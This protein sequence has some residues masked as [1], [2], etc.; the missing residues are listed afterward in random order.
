MAYLRC[1]ACGS[2]ALRAA[3]QCP[4][5]AAPFDLID[6]RGFRAQLKQCGGCGILHRRDLSCHWCG[7]LPAA[8]WRS[9]KV[10]GIAAG[11]AL[12]AMAASGAYRFRAPIAE[13]A[14]LIVA[15]VFEDRAA[16]AAAS[17]RDREALSMQ[18]A[19]SGAPSSVNTG[20]PQTVTTDSSG[21]LLDE[22][23]LDDAELD[24][25]ML[26]A[27]AAGAVTSSDS[28]VWTPAVARTWV[29]VRNDASRGGNVVGVINPSSRALLGTTRSGWRQVKSTD[30]TGWVDPKLFEADSTRTRG[31]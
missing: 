11:I 24:A 29:N 27:D 26:L 2:K 4:R 19:V 9:P 17:A 25:S 23:L 22:S 1:E 31:I 6:A 12:I 13:T 14:S 30:V 8:R 15:R 16:D 18:V 21:A 7:E 20:V 5:C 3:S 28:I 10:L